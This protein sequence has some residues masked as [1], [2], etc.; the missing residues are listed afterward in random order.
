MKE[1]TTGDPKFVELVKGYIFDRSNELIPSGKVVE[2]VEI[3]SN[4]TETFVGWRIKIHYC[5]TDQPS[6]LSRL[7]KTNVKTHE[8]TLEQLMGW[9]WFNKK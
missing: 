1:H 3:D 6:I 5:W 8:V 2:R 7:L 4:K 9:M